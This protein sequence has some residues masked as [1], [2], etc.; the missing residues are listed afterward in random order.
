VVTPLDIEWLIGLS[1]RN[2]FAGE[3]FES[4]LFFNRP[5]PGWNQYRTPIA[6]CYQC[7]SG[8]HPGGCVSGGPGWLATKQI[9]GDRSRT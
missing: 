4:P 5:A 3:L 8:T 2:I 7:G 9:L 6:G 1:E